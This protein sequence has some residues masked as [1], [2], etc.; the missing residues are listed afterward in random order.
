MQE[1]ECCILP[2]S[3]L[4]FRRYQGLENFQ[5]ETDRAVTSTSQ[6]SLNR[7]AELVHESADGKI[8]RKNI[9]RTTTLIGSHEQSNL[10][11]LASYVEPSH[12]VLTLDGRGFRIWDLRSKSGTFVNGERVSSARLN[13][14]DEIRIGKFRFTLETNLSDTTREGFFIDEYRVVGIL[15]TG[16]MGW[17]YVVEDGRTLQRHALKVLTRKAAS[18]QVD[19]GELQAR[20]VFEGRAGNRLKNPHIVEVLDYQH[21]HDVEYLL[22]ELFESINLQELVQRDGPLPVEQVCSVFR[23]VALGLGHIHEISLIHRDIKPANILVGHDGHTK[24]CDFGLVFLGDDPEELK[25]A[26]TMG[27]DCLGT[28]DYISP[29]QSYDSYKIDHRADQYSLG[30][31]MYFALTGKLPFPEGNTREKINLHRSQ[32]PA[33]IQ[34]IAPDV[35]TEVCQIV[36]RC[37]QKNPDDRYQ[38]DLALAAD[39]KKFATTSISISFDFEKLLRKRTHHASFRLADPKKKHYLQRI[40]AN[41]ASSLQ[42]MSSQES[43]SDDHTTL[44]PPSA[45]GIATHVPGDTS[46]TT[47][48]H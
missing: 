31:S 37:M 17:L 39:L 27:N 4:F 45:S 9:L 3:I 47:E 33:G 6:N 34:S 35:P 48:P 18:S 46:S 12:C 19:Q 38:S 44:S 30:C 40:P 13:N 8:V 16:G 11:L 28:A 7:R 15:G 2:Q 42:A 26:E 43:L 24:I 20:F 10:Q 23:Q 22:L 21:R 1:L 29:E 5:I 36:E 32:D 25:L 14:G 41:V